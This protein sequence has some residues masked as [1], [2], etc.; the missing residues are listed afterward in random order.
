VVNK[1]KILL[2]KYPNVDVTAMGFPAT[3]KEE[4]LWKFIPNIKQRIRL[5]VAF[6]VR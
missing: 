1:F 6:K 4:P 3:W 2:K 5:A